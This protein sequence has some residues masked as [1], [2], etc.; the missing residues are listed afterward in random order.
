MPHRLAVAA[1]LI[2]AVALPLPAISGA[3]PVRLEAVVPLDAPDQALFA[4]AVLRSSNAARQ[5][6][7][8][9]PLRLDPGLARAASGHAR[10]MARLRTHA[11]VLPVPGEATLGQ[12][13]RRQSLR[14]RLAG[15]NIARDKALRLLGRPISVAH[16]GCSFTYADTGTPVPRHSYAS[17]AEQ[18]VGRWLAS[19]QHRASLLSPG[20]TRLG[21][22][23]A[24][25]PTAPACGDFYL[26]QTFAD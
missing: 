6:H 24:A 19:P 11:H 12:R 18:V 5:A 26:V 15:E 22:G 17:L 3:M 14:F 1:W 20:F 13:M 10:N 21:A 23:I 8:R 4:E 9:P 16:A 2:A 7:G 25:D